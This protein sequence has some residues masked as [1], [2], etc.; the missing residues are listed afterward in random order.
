MKNGEYRNS[1]ARTRRARGC[2]RTGAGETPTAADTAAAAAPPSTTRGARRQP[3]GVVGLA[4]PCRPPGVVPC[5]RQKTRS[6]DLGAGDGYLGGFMGGHVSKGLQGG[7]FEHSNCRD[8][9][10]WRFPRRPIHGGPAPPSPPAMSGLPMPLHAHDDGGGRKRPPS[11]PSAPTAVVTGGG[12][13]GGGR[14]RRQQRRC[15][16]VAAATSPPS[17]NGGGLE[18]LSYAVERPSPRERRD[19]QRRSCARGWWRR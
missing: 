10:A 17:T 2:V 8:T 16:R 1:R 14:R 5:A 6:S 13:S 9:S 7:T 19:G 4:A 12:T 18:A 11:L 15:V 3:A